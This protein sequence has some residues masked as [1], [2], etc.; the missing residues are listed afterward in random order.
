MGWVRSISGRGG[1]CVASIR[2][3]AID[4]LCVHGYKST[5]MGR[6]DP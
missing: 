6:L 3:A 4:L 5:V 1:D 2:G